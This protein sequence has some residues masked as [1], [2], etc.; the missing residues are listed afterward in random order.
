MRN[1]KVIQK[2]DWNQWFGYRWAESER[3]PAKQTAC[4]T[5]V[6][7]LVINFYR[8]QQPPDCPRPLTNETMVPT[9][10]TQMPTL[11]ILEMPVIGTQCKLTYTK[12]GATP[13]N[14]PTSSLKTFLSVSEYVSARKNKYAKDGKHMSF[15]VRI[16]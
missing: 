11:G 10:H 9:Q 7:A 15:S 1:P 14:P 5:Y 13:T 12:T 6:L 16:I 8:R 2:K 3:C 4:P